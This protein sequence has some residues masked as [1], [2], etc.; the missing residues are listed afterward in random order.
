MKIRYGFVSNSSSSSFLIVGITD[1]SIIDKI[2]KHKELTKEEIEQEM[3]FGMYNSEDLDFLGNGE[4]EYVGVELDETELDTKPLI[5]IKQEFADKIK[6]DY[7]III[8]I[9]KIRMHYG[10]VST[11]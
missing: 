4:I 2:I 6:R 8:P 9:D 3:N 10:E 5:I 7:N 11:G 1:D